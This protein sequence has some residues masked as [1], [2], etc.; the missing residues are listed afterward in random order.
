MP[1]CDS[2]VL[3]TCSN[4]VLTHH[5]SYARTTPTMKPKR[6][7]ASA[8]IIMRIM[9]IRMSPWSMPRTPASPQIPIDMPEA[10]PDRPTQRPEARCL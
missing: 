4:G 2:I 8:K 9:A 10:M 5:H 3:I 1:E 7:M 6:A